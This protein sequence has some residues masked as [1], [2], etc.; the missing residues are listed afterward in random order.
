ML[1]VCAELT[2]CFVAMS[3]VAW[4]R[5]PVRSDDYR[6]AM[7]RFLFPFAAAICLFAAVVGIHQPD[8]P[9]HLSWVLWTGVAV[10]VT[11]ARALVEV[12]HY[13]MRRLARTSKRLRKR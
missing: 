13:R 8:P 11:V 9:V 5:Y 6:L 4:L 1:L 2:S 3:V 10:V 12:R 7:G